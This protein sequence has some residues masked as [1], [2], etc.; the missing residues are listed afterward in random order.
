MVQTGVQRAFGPRLRQILGGALSNRFQAFL[1]GLGVTAIL[2]SSTATGLMVAGFA[3]GGLVDL[4]PALAVM[5]G[6][7]VGTTLI[8][9]VLSFNVAAVSPGS[10]PDRRADVPPRRLSRTRD[11]GRVADRPRPDADGAAPIR[12]SCVTPYEDVPSL[13]LLL[14][15]VATQPA[16]GRAARGRRDLGGAF[17]R[18]RRAAGD[19]ARRQGRRA[20]RRRLRPGARR[21]SR[22][23]HQPGAGRRP[24]TDAAARRLPVGNL[25]NRVVG[26]LPSPCRCCR[27][28]AAGS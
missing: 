25:L 8:V 10:D 12:S 4:V 11:L 14:G 15:A 6:A 3:A 17:Q 16:A 20:A 26:V 23:R 18:R 1:A 7:N 21:Q 2:Q 28:S 9:Q 13:R 24:A 22:H 5:L 19:V 27:R